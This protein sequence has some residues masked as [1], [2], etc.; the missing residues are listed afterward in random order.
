MCL[1]LRAEKCLPRHERSGGADGP[2]PEPAPHAAS[3]QPELSALRQAAAKGRRSLALAPPI[4]FGVTEGRVLKKVR[5]KDQGSRLHGH[6][7]PIVCSVE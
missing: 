3:K 6:P 4:S 2:A 7:H 1:V 5:R